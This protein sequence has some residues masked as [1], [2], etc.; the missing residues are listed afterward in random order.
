MEWSGCGGWSGPWA[1]TVARPCTGCSRSVVGKIEDRHGWD[2]WN[3]AA[4]WRESSLDSVL[5]N[6]GARRSAA[7]A[8]SGCTGWAPKSTVT[9]WNTFLRSLRVWEQATP[10]AFGAADSTPSAGPEGALAA[11]RAEKS[12]IGLVSPIC[13]LPKGNFANGDRRTGASWR[14][15]ALVPPSPL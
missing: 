6:T 10:S 15:I 11:P 1:R 3:L 13:M 7:W 8:R 5:P 9:S 4:D 12:K 2:V 14:P